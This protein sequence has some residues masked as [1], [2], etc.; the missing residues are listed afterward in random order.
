MVARDRYVPVE[1]KES[2]E[3]L[4][5][6]LSRTSK[7]TFMN[8]VMENDKDEIDKGKLIEESINQGVG[9]FSPDMMFESVVKDYKTAEKIYG[10]KILRIIFGYD[11]NYIEKNVKIP[12]FQKILKDNARQNVK[13]LI[14]DGVLDSQGA[15]TEKGIELASLVMYTQ[16][17]DNIVP[18]GISG[19]KMHKKESFYGGRDE[20]R[21]YR[22]GDR[23]RDI[24]IKKS[25]KTAIRRQHEKMGFEDLKVFERKSKGKCYII[26]AVDASGSMKGKKISVAKKAGIALAFKAIQEKDNVGLLVFGDE[27]KEI[28][29]PCTDFMRILRKLTTIRASAQ[30]DIVMTIKKA[31]EMFPQGNVT[32]HLLFLTDALPTKGEDPEKETLDAVALA[33]EFGITISLV[34]LGLDKKGRELAQKI[35]EL[36]RGKLYAV[37]NL[38]DV[39]KIVLQDYYSVY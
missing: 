21:T 11:P 4:E 33:A 24:D 12:E 2:I 8:S 39:D 28:V 6:K 26:Y 27:I 36:G 19:E 1:E 3:E 31:I 29:E 23:Y 30:T 34:G 17:L 15:I 22:K 13:R 38:D 37:S 14:K 18:R 20:G 9:S 25:I 10:E 35:V 32:K 5:G 16:E 7:E